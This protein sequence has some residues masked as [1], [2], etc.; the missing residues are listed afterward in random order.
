M[1]TTSYITIYEQQPITNS[2]TQNTI[3]IFKCFITP[4]ISVWG[5]NGNLS[6]L[7]G[8][9]QNKIYVSRSEI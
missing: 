5:K 4:N 1:Y 7:K 6:K 2:N 8:K 3:L 9:T